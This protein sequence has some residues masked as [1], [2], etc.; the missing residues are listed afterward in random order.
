MIRKK[1]PQVSKII[2]ELRK[3][4]DA[5]DEN[6]P[7]TDF[8]DVEDY[9][10][11]ELWVPERDY[12]M[13]SFSPDLSPERIGDLGG[14]ESDGLAGDPP[15]P[16]F[17]IPP[18]VSIGQAKELLGDDGRKELETLRQER[19]VDAFA[20]YYPFHFPSRQWGVYI[21]MKGLVG[22]ALTSG[23][24][25]EMSLT[26]ALELSFYAL[27][28]HELMHFCVEY[29]SAQFEVSTRAAGYIRARRSLKDKSRQYV[30]KEEE[31]ANAYMLRRI[32]Y[33]PK[34]KRRAGAFGALLGAVASSP[35]GY[36]DAASYFPAP[37]RAFDLEAFDRELATYLEEVCSFSKRRRGF[38]GDCFDF[39]ALAPIDPSG[40]VDWRL[41]PVFLIND[42]DWF[43]WDPSWAGYFATVSPIDETPKFQKMLTKLDGN[44]QRKWAN[45]KVRLATDAQSRKN[46]DFKKWPKGG[47]NAWSVRVADKNFRAHLR[48]AAECWEAYEI[49]THKELGHG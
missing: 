21:P 31:L 32:K 5:L 14:E 42:S 39:S 3:I 36:R 38:P 45:V 47:N 49:G 20:W 7:L 28:Q 26:E 41:C 35:P 19:G 27:L 37:G 46:L 1:N 43:E 2:Q 22:F 11:E 17:T 9:P 40:R 48:Y 13:E 16:I 8:S 34:S 23:L 18:D 25:D 12:G 6:P 33:P 4:E 30:R 15:N 29:V 10:V 44:I 24:A